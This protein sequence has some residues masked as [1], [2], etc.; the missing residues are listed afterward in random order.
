VKVLVVD[1]NPIVRTGLA[2]TLRSLPEVEEVLEADNGREGLRMLAEHDVHVV[3]L[4]FR[5]PVMD[6]LEMLREKDDDTPVLMLSHSDEADIIRE[7]LSL[8]ARG[9]LVHGSLTPDELA[10]ALTTAIHGGAVF[11]QA[12]AEVMLAPAPVEPAKARVESDPWHLTDRERELVEELAQGQSNAQ[13]ARTLFLAEKT[14]KNH[15]GR[16]Y[17]K[18][19]VANRAEAIVAW[20]QRDQGPS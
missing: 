2:V 11:S 12:A 3:L 16:I 13:I 20:H 5:M 4:D 14:V 8:G 19:G 10:S 6:G 1:D 7:A 17:T 9:Y 18:M 15:F